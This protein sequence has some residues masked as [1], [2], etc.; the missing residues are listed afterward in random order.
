ML[1]LL[2]LFAGDALAAEPLLDL[3]RVR[4]RVVVVDFWASWCTPCRRSIP[5]LNEM[6]A[7]YADRGLVI[8]GVNV[9][10]SRGDAEQFLA[11]VPARFEI[12]YDPDGRL[13][14][15]FGVAAMPSSYVFD[16]SGKVV[17]R[18][19][20]FQNARRAEYEKVLRELL[21]ADGQSRAGLQ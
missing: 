10:K 5:W 2:A 3:D 17:A 1:V 14:A 8:I 9:D 21:H 12:V 11:A 4:G 13:P 7:K 20:G 18:H 6:Q 19:L 15:K 16:R